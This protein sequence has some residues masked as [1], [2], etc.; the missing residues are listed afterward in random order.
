MRPRGARGAPAPLE[1][2]LRPLVQECTAGD[3]MRAGVLG[4]NLSRRA[5]SRRL[6]AL[7][8][9]ASRRTIRRLLRQLTIGCRTA[10][11][12]KT[13]GHP[14]DRHAPFDNMARLRREYEAAG[15]AVMSIATQKKAWR[16]HVHRAGTPLTAETV[17]T[18]KHDFGSAGQ[19]ALIPHGLYDLM[20]PHAHIHRN[21]RHAASA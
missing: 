8:T 2:P 15:E 3:P 6:G 1:A 12:Q 5:L 18:C 14:P 20:N 10:W 21:A 7:G 4:T 13:M 17:E 19:G 11:K 9:P 16:G